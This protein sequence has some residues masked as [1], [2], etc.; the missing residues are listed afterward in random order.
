ML[1]HKSDC[2]L[3]LDLELLGVMLKNHSAL[4]EMY[5]TD[6]TRSIR[7]IPKSFATEGHSQSSLLD[8]SSLVG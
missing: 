6:V 3:F 2:K 8:N 7:M 5:V 1:G 4:K